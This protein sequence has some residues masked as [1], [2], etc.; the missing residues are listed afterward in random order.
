M[1]RK[2]PTCDCA[3]WFGAVQSGVISLLKVDGGLREMLILS[4]KW[5]GGQCPTT[6]WFPGISSGRVAARKGEQ[7]P[8]P[9]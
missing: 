8:L 7:A 3:S 4:L 5:L 1:S 9:N 6:R 2:V